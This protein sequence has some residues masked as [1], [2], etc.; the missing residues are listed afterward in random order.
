MVLYFLIVR[1]LKKAEGG[2]SIYLSLDVVIQYIIEKALREAYD[3]HRP[4]S[5]V[6]LVMDPHNAEVLGMASE[7]SF[8]PNYF[9]YY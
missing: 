6:I 8:N 5:A 9:P 2:T 7:P 1:I 4:K 3:T